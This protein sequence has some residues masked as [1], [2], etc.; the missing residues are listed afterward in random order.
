MHDK[1]SEREVWTF[2]RIDTGDDR[3]VS[4]EEF[5]ADGIKAVVEKW[6]GSEIEDMGA[7]FDAIDT[8][9]GVRE[10]KRKTS[11]FPKKILDSNAH[12]KLMNKSVPAIG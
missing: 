3:R 1:E 10:R 9:G 12:F 11:S 5:T 8:N 7:E 6:T 4:K 2:P